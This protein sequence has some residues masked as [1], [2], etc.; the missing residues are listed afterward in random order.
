MG[1]YGI[2]VSRLVAT[3][4]E[5]N[6]DPAGIVWPSEVSPYKLVV[7][8]LDIT[9]PK[10]MEFASGVY[11]DM[12]ASGIE[13]LFDDRDE[14]AGVKFKDADLIGV[15][16][17]VIVGKESVKKNTIELKVRKDNSKTVDTPEA[18]VR[19]VKGLLS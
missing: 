14:R 5:Q 11:R 18:V 9:D 1:C 6:H 2:G 19:R 10:I 16:L 12:K 15:P 13:V 4:I 8:P 3:I 17:Q 7:L